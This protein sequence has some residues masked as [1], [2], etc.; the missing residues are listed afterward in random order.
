MQI[1]PSILNAHF[2]HLQL[3]INSLADADRL[4]LDIMDGHYVPALT[5]GPDLFTQ[6]EV[7]LPHE[8]HLM[9]QHPENFVPQWIK[10]GAHTI[11]FHIEATGLTSALNLLKFIKAQGIRAGISIDGYT[12][13]AY[14][15]DEVLNL[16][17]QVLIMS[18]K[19]GLGGQAF[20][21][22]SLVKCKMLRERGYTGE[23]EFDGGVKPEQIPLIAKAGGDIC[24]V[25]SFLMN[26]PADQR[27]QTIAK[28]QSLDQSSA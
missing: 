23:I 16:A 19:A 25:G 26:F 5:F 3:E 17:D 27:S 18:V 20:L 28:L 11:T 6:I 1:A 2:G 7:P 15:T 10:T 14:L 8:V 24:V 4:H 21:P 12:S 9:V 22:Q 13:P